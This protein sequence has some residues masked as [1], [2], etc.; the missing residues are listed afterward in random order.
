M[1]KPKKNYSKDDA[2]ARTFQKMFG[3]GHALNSSE[4]GGASTKDAQSFPGRESVPNGVGSMCSLGESG[5][6]P[7]IGCKFMLDPEL[8]KALKYRA[9]Q[10]TSKNLSEHVAAALEQYLKN[11]LAFVRENLGNR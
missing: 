2:N 4:T 6:K 5:L 1:T 10:D 9:L 8:H 11:D 3:T 7:K